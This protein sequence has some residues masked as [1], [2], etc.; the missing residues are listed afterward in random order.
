MTSV[1]PRQSTPGSIPP[2][3]S[4]W[5]RT[6][7]H[8]RVVSAPR[9]DGGQIS[10]TRRIVC[11]DGQTFVLKTAEAA[12][13]PPLPPDLYQREAEGLETLATAGY[14]TTP[15]V[16]LVDPGFLLLDDLGSTAPT[17]ASFASAGRQLALQHHEQVPRFGF[18]TDNYL[19]RIVQRNR[20]DADGHTFFAEHRV[21]RYLEVPLA[22]A[23]IPQRD[24]VRLER[25]AAR[26]PE[27]VPRQP[28]CL[29]HGDLWAA[30]ML[31]TPEGGPAV[32][33]PAVYYGWP[34]AELS[35][36]HECGRVDPAFFSAY[37]EIHPLEAGWE[38]RMVLLHVRE[39]LSTIAHFGSGGGLLARLQTVLDRFS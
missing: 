15:A 4:T 39:V 11:T 32:V 1:S 28:A 34:E 29:V 24:R 31:T 33:D 13:S 12:S 25:I 38:D 17:R 26:L 36:V 14:L 22:A 5:L 19:G 37:L 30:N 7:G 23:A 6:R 18:G 10:L 8:G 35:M 21:L 20:W 27:L 16:H 2:E 9:L 3:V